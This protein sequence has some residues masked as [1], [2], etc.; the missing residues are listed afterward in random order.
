MDEKLKQYWNSNKLMFFLVVIPLG[1]AFLAFT[2]RDLIFAMLAGSARKTV[3][4]AKKTDETLKG[5]VDTAAQDAAKAQAAADA[6]A[7]RI[8]DRK[9][10][11]ISEDWHKKKD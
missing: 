1:L 7:K 2:F 9:E 4:E 11:D 5:K 6:A 10:D 8:A 3:E